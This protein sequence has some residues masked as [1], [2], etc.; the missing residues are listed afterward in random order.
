MTAEMQTFLKKHRADCQARHEE[1]AG[2]VRRMGALNAKLI[3]LSGAGQLP[4][5]G[6]KAIDAAIASK[7]EEAIDE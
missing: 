1:A 5:R 4:R 6:L 7:V 2:C 3:F